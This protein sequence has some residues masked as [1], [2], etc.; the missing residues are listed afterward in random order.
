MSDDP[1][2]AMGAPLLPVERPRDVPAGDHLTLLAR[3]AGFH[4]DRESEIAMAQRPAG[5]EAGPAAQAYDEHTAGTSVRATDLGRRM[6]IASG[7]VEAA[8]LV[9]AAGGA[10]YLFY[11]A[12]A[13]IARQVAPQSV[14]AAQSAALRT[15]AQMQLAM[16]KIAEVFD[17][18]KKHPARSGGAARV[19]GG[20]TPENIVRLHLDAVRGTLEAAQRAANQAR[21]TLEVNHVR[22]R[23]AIVSTRSRHPHSVGDYTVRYTGDWKWHPFL[24]PADREA[25]V[26]ARGGLRE[27]SELVRFAGERLGLARGQ[28]DDTLAVTRGEAAARFRQLRFEADGLAGER[29]RLAE[30]L[31]GLAQR[32]DGREG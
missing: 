6:D 15:D 32:Y 28:I 8:A 14:P 9:A 13:G 27:Q 31:R 25:M 3:G 19:G 16:R 29:E 5:D 11:A 2:V 10:A 12:Y 7:G 1:L 26:A 17:R 20:A 24:S 22:I 21:G 23:D 30:R 18:L 4:R